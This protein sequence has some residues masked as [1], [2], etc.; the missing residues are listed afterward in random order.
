MTESLIIIQQLV[1]N[2]AQNMTM[3]P[4]KFARFTIMNRQMTKYEKY[5]ESLESMEE[6]QVPQVRF[7]M[8]GLIE[9]AK[10]QG[11]RIIDLPMSEKQKFIHPL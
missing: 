8:R 10:E 9:Y 2:L 1:V 5:L 7:D 3:L 11:K 6:P 4:E